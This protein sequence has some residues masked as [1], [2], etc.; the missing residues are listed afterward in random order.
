M[1]PS[2]EFSLSIS[3]SRG[4]NRRPRPHSPCSRPR[5]YNPHPRTRP[6]ASPTPLTCKQ[7]GLACP[8]FCLS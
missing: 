5:I 3:A 7:G 4:E 6:T 1:S 2:S 8:S